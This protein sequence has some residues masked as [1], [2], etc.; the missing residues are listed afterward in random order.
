M[1]SCAFARAL[2]FRI[3]ASAP[4]AATTANATLTNNVQRHDR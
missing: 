2:A 4:I 1:S 3:R